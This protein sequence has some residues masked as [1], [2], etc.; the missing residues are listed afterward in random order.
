MR[1]DPEP[2]PVVDRRKM[3]SRLDSIQIHHLNKEKEVRK[4]KG[5]QSIDTNDQVKEEDT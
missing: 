2:S 4:L 1:L 3:L 5:R